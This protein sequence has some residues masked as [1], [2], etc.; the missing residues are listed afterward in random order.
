MNRSEVYAVIN[1]ER[2]HQDRKWGT[3]DERPK[4]V[5]SWLTLLRAILTKAE[6]EWAT[7]NVDD[8]ALSEIRKLAATA[9]ACMEQH[10]AI[11]RE[12]DMLP[13]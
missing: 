12:S 11:D 8:C 4:E 5:G 1:G 9:V 13:G 7:A 2:D 3:I 6:T 10:G